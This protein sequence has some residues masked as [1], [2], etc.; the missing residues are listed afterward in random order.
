MKKKKLKIVNVPIESIEERYSADWNVWFPKVFSEVSFIKSVHNVVGVPQLVEGITKGEFLDVIGTHYYKASQV[1]QLCRL[2][3]QDYLDE[4]TVVFFNDLWFPGIEALFYIKDAL[5]LKFRIAGILHAGTYDPWDYITQK[6][7]GK[8]AAAMESQWFTYVDRIFVA[9]HYHKRLITSARGTLLGDKIE[10]TGLPVMNADQLLKRSRSAIKRRRV[11][12][13]HRLAPEKQ[14]EMFEHMAYVLSQRDVCKGWEFKSTKKECFTKSEYY[15]YLLESAIVVSCAK[16]ETFGIAQRE[17]LYCG[18]VPVQPW[19]LS[20]KE[21]FPGSVSYSSFLEL[22]CIVQELVS[23]FEKEKSLPFWLH[24]L[25][26]KL[27]TADSNVAI[28]KMAESMRRLAAL[29][30]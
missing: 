27:A 2:A 13:P 14:P 21:F 10:V 18:C 20:Y 23:I 8:W 26:Q 28:I 22:L 9:S 29:D 3:Q 16:Q 25:Q 30:R 15:E 7:M 24:P 4:N 5:G 19:G 11:V 1:M 17:A 12:F 6:G